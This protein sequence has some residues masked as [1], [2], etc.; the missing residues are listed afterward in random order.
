MTRPTLRARVTEAY[1]AYRAGDTAALRRLARSLW[2]D[3]IPDGSTACPAHDGAACALCG[4]RGHLLPVDG[5]ALATRAALL[6]DAA[7]KAWPSDRPAVYLHAGHAYADVARDPQTRRRGRALALAVVAYCEAGQQNEAEALVEELSVYASDAVL[8]AVGRRDL[9]LRRR[10]TAER[11]KIVDEGSGRAR[12][13][14]V[15]HLLEVVDE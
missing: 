4:G 1:A 13:G 5:E 12:I 7:A 6:I 11:R 10:A 8:M 14:P 9:I 15:L 3:T 2:P